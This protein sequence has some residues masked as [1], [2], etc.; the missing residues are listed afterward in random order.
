MA[1][2][3]IVVIGAS[4]GGIE[5]LNQL[6]LSLKPNLPAALMVVIHMP[7]DSKSNLPYILNRAKTMP[8]S[9]A[10]DGQTIRPGQVYV[11]PPN[12]HL[13]VENGSIILNVGPKENG[14]RPAVDPLFI[15]TAHHYG[16]RVAGVVLSGNLSD[17]SKGLVSIKRAGGVTIVQDPEEAMYPGMPSSALQYVRA[18]YVETATNIGLLINRL[19]EESFLPEGDSVVNVPD[20]E[21][22]HLI[23]NEFRKYENGAVKNQSSVLTCP[24]CGGVLWE[25]RA[26][27]LIHYRC[28]IG[29]DYSP[30][31]LLTSQ[32]SEIE[33]AFWSAIRVLVEKA[34]LSNRLAGRAK[35]NG[36]KELEKFYLDQAS[37]AEKDAD[38]IRHTWFRA[39][40]ED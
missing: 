4:A 37:K 20:S 17:G 40:G 34:A 8:A 24:E 35:I 3:D 11:G 25:L 16:P 26:G 31:A 39:Q 9:F 18:D 30:E 32:D 33:N 22:H 7:S 27:E 1:K 28:H 6:F 15:S 13:L 38:L 10:Q 14:F 21:E 36:N 2:I 12:Y 23:Q 29:H 5:A 19:T